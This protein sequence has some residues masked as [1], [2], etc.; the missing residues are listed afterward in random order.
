MGNSCFANAVTAACAGIPA[1]R[2]ALAEHASRACA[3]ASCA[4]CALYVNF[5]RRS[6]GD[7]R[8]ANGAFLLD[9]MKL[10]YP[11]SWRQQHDPHEFLSLLT[12]TLAE[13]GDPLPWTDFVSFP[14]ATVFHACPRCGTEQDIR[15]TPD[16]CSLEMPFPR[17][18][19]AGPISLATMCASH[20]AVDKDDFLKR[21][22]GCNHENT[23]GRVLMGE[24]P[25]AFYILV[26]RWDT[27]S[28]R[29]GVP[30]VTK[31]SAEL[32]ISTGCVVD[33][34]T[35]CDFSAAQEEAARRAG[36][37]FRNGSSSS[38]G[39]FAESASERAMTV[40]IKAVR[41]ARYESSA[42]HLLQ[43]P[44]MFASMNR[45]AEVPSGTTKR[46]AARTHRKTGGPRA[47]RH[48]RARS[49]DQ[50]CKGKTACRCR[51]ARRSAIPG[52]SP[53]SAARAAAASTCI[54]PMAASP[55]FLPRTRIEMH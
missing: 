50:R 27:A 18:A 25:R 22:K 34:G 5:H 43:R 36:A 38:P 15:V 40:L 35:F 2:R 30:V 12:E 44:F 17:G 16:L 32:D 6:H 46:R 41:P 45:A 3:R 39:N 7:A 42:L 53:R 1:F 8:G 13:K 37:T 19:G 47:F 26:K 55:N 51:K 52:Q 9:A 33:M 48:L 20:F 23:G 54:T 11:Q 49:E 28:G 29:G 31:N 4:A 14:L 21:C 24:A 10:A